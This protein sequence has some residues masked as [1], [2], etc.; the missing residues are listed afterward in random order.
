MCAGLSITKQRKSTKRTRFRSLVTGVHRLERVRPGFM[1]EAKCQ[2]VWNWETQLRTR[3]A[4]QNQNRKECHL[5]QDP[6]VS[7]A[8][9]GRVLTC[10]RRCFRA[11]RGEVRS[12]YYEHDIFGTFPTVEGGCKETRNLTAY[13]AALTDAGR[14]EGGK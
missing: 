2:P 1:G 11:E 5:T 7:H 4:S 8:R 9:R 13:L 10:T 3:N 6:R 12:S 14:K